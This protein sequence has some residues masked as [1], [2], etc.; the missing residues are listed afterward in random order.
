MGKLTQERRRVLEHIERHSCGGRFPCRVPDA[1]I[2][3]A[4]QSLID[5]QTAIRTGG[6]VLTPAGRAAL[7]DQGERDG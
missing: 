2:L 5:G 4:N 3:E 7:S 6:R 1:W